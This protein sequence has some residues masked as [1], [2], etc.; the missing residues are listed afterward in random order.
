M[1]TMWGGGYLFMYALHWQPCL[2]VLLAGGGMASGRVVSSV[3]AVYAT[4]LVMEILWN[5]RF[6]ESAWRA[7]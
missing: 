7:L 2:L 3:G 1:F 6:L 4:L 5:V